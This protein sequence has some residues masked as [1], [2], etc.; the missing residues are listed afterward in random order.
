MKA[1]VRLPR[2]LAALLR[3]AGWSRLAKGLSG[4]SLYLV[5]P[6]DGISWVMKILDRRRFAT[7]RVADE[8][9]RLRW[10][11]GKLPV[12]R[13]VWCGRSERREFLLTTRIP[14][15]DCDKTDAP[16]RTV[17]R[18]L[19]RALR[20]IHSLPIENCPFDS[21]LGSRLAN[22]KGYIERGVGHNM[23]EDEEGKLWRPSVYLRYLAYAQPDGEDLVFTHGD[24]CHPNVIL[25]GGELSGIVDWAY[26]GV[27][28]RHQDL[29]WICFLIRR[30]YGK[31]WLGVFLRHYGLA[32][33]DPVKMQYYLAL[34]EVY[35]S[36]RR[37]AAAR[38][39]GK[40]HA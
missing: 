33:L 26:A 21:T 24:F 4:D 39:K 28:D 22:I 19:A 29:A 40:L 37:D 38:V 7:R 9:Q 20:M 10:L 36:A 14:G 31:R 15:Q 34:N 11:A 16:R 30:R 5:R 8:C 1:P 13:V 35:W 27:A 6:G 3:G 12:P 2:R 18:E 25:N 23:F 32:R 17:V